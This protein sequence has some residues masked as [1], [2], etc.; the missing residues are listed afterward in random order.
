LLLNAGCFPAAMLLA[1]ARCLQESSKK[2]I[3]KQGRKR[4]KGGNK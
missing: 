3:R 1:A 4:E 2:V